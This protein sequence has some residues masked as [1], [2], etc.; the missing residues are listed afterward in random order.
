MTTEERL[1]KL[2]GALTVEA[3]LTAR[4]ERKVEAWIESAENRF[5]E[6]HVRTIAFEER[7]DAFLE[8]MDRFM[9][10]REGNGHPGGE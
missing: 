3:E 10:G 6:L 7:F 9:Q 5:A 8:R 4:F 1:Q 2:E